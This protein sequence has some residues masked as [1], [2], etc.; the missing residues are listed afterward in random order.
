MLSA[1]ESRADAANAAVVE[2]W[3]EAN[4]ILFARAIERGEIAADTDVETLAWVI[5]SMATYRV[6]VQRKPIPTSWVAMLVDTVLLPAVGL[7]P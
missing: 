4:R 3:V 2:P 5:P 6:G 7:A 1:E